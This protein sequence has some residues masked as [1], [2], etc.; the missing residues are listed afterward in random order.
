MIGYI[1][2][3]G[4]NMT[5]VFFT[6]D[7][8][9][10][11]GIYQQGTRPDAP[12]ALILHPNPQLGGTMNNKVVYTMFQAFVKLGFSVLRFNFRGVGK[13]Q[14]IFNADEETELSDTLTA[15]EWLKN[16]N[17]EASHTWI[18]GYSYGA[19]VGLSV[20]MRRPDINGFVA[21]SPPADVCDFSYLSPCPAS[22]IIIQ[23]GADTIVSEPAVA[24]LA[25]RLDTFKKVQVKYVML[26]NADHLYTNQLKNVF[27][28]LQENVPPL[29]VPKK[30]IVKRKKRTPTANTETTK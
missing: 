1:Q 17:P 12:I 29:L 30:R 28:A 18:A 25:E 9:R 20:L 7:A 15:L 2:Q 14:G 11:E 19:S 6:G 27:D 4:L 22:G 24:M 21:M 5:E 23:G 13:S 26:E 16:M 3:K 10:L 8:G